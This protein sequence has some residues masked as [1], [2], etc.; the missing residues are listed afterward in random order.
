ML[1]SFAFSHSIPG[2]RP[3][4]RIIFLSLVLIKLLTSG[5]TALPGANRTAQT[6]TVI[7]QHGN[8]PLD[9]NRSV[10]QDYPGVNP[11][12]ILC[13]SREEALQLGKSFARDTGANLLVTSGSN[14]MEPLI[15]GRTYV[16]V[17]PRPYDRISKGDL[18]VYQGRPD[19]AK[20]D[21]TCM[22]HRAVLQDKAGWLMSGDNN[23]W[24][25]SW[26]RVTPDTYQG[27][28]TT[29]LEFPQT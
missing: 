26:D 8:G 6:A 13:Q 2:G 16:V 7:S 23:R 22:L 29:I 9:L 5:C 18:L 25:E 19:G 21:R 14:S 24:T 17:Q 12:K 10:S 27:T 28:V 1:T 3:S 20:P 11:K 4:H 15:H